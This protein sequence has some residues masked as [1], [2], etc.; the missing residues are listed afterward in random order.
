[1]DTLDRQGVG[2]ELNPDAE[3]DPGEANQPGE[4]LVGSPD[5]LASV[6]RD[7]VTA[8]PPDQLIDAHV[9]EVAAI[10]QV[11]EVSQAIGLAGQFAG[12]QLAR[13]RPPRRP[14]RPTRILD[15]V[16]EPGVEEGQEA[17]SIPD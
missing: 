2:V 17:G 14:V 11:N 5:V 1:M 9:F 13:P 15:P 8:A 12:E 6:E 7:D 4:I 10:G 3:I 16:A